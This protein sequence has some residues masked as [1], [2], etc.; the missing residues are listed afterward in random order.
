MDPRKVF[1]DERFTGL[2]VYCGAE[3][4]TRDHVPSKVL[5][6][7]PFPADLPVVPAC[8]RCNNRFSLD[9]QYLA[10]LV[11][12]AITGSTDPDLVRRD[13]VK[14][15]LR[16]NPVLA[17]RL[18]AARRAEEAGTVS[19]KPEAD[20]VRNV[21][22]KLARGHAAYEYSEPQLGDPQHVSFI[23]ACAM[24]PERFRSF[25]TLHAEQ[26][27]PEIG[28]RAFL[29]AVVVGNEAFLDDGGWCVV[30]EGRYRYAVSQ[31]MVRLVLSEYLACEII[32]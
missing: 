31:T 22:L 16:E 23:P 9:E 10:C 30:Q 2:C 21:V 6:D 1:A 18:A 7:E 3:P 28:S 19:W 14:R 17:A 8:Q 4:D 20:R 15:I 5:L 24:S 32:W 11:E 27:W 25:E 13:K 29:R 26:L 12:C